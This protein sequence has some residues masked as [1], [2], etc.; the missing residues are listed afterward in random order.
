MRRRRSPGWHRDDFVSPG[1]GTRPGHGTRLACRSSQA[2]C[3]WLRWESQN[4]GA[5]EEFRA[6]IQIGIPNGRLAPGPCIQCGITPHLQ[7]GPDNSRIKFTGSCLCVILVPP[8]RLE[9]PLRYRKQIL[10]LP[11]LPIPPQG[12]LLARIAHNSQKHGP[13]NPQPV[14]CIAPATTAKASPAPDN[15]PA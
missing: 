13:V 6:G 11:R 1:Y 9:L 3:G 15:N 8:G 5:S 2:L 12:P 7:T 10:N 14:P 4:Q